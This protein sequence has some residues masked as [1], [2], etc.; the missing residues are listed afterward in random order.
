MS[1]RA[2]I[3]ASAIAGMA[4]AAAG[5]QHIQCGS[6]TATK[7][8][9]LVPY[10]TGATGQLN[11]SAI[12]QTSIFNGPI[13]SQLTQLPTATSAPGAVILVIHGNPEAY[14]NLGPILVDRPDSVGRGSLV[15]G[16]SAEQFRFN[17]LDGIPINAIPLAYAQT[18]A[19]QT[20]TQTVDAS[21]KMNQYVLVGTYG[22][23]GRTDIS[24]VVPFTRISIGAAAVSPQSY[25]DLTGVAAIASGGNNKGAARGIGDI[26]FN[27]KHVLWTGGEG[28]RGSA[29]AGFGMRFPTGDALNYLGSG[30]YGFNVYALA[31]Y[32]ARL[33]PH[34]KVGYVWNTNSVLLNVSGLGADQKLPGGFGSALGVDFAASRHITV[35]ADVISNEFQNSP[36]I[37]LTT[38]NQT[39][40]YSQGSYGPTAASTIGNLPT[41][42]IV[43][44]TFTAADFS[45]G[46][47]WKPFSKRNLVLYGNVLIPINDVGLR[48]DPSPSVGISY[49]FHGPDSWPKWVDRNND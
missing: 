17:H 34:V 27:L 37:A 38:Y 21:I 22:L 33:S 31:A 5:A 14:D 1:M 43:N 29:A 12:D 2:K 19:G 48:T 24:V 6:T 18:T 13:G 46:V 7:L 26:D 10:S 4:W 20:Y 8:V 11:S 28:G 35:A 39:T 45:G 16:F 42:N 32:K 23:P 15:L 49:S 36:S 44:H 40:S 9:C 3:I 47:K 25:S 30:A 41:V